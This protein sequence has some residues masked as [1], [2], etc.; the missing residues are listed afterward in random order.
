MNDNHIIVCGQQVAIGPMLAHMMLTSQDLQDCLLGLVAQ[1]TAIPEKTFPIIQFGDIVNGTIT[2]DLENFGGFPVLTVR[3]SDDDMTMTFQHVGGDSIEELE[4]TVDTESDAI[5]MLDTS[6]GDP[7][8]E[9]RPRLLPFADSL[10]WMEFIQMRN[11]E[12]APSDDGKWLVTA[13]V[14]EDHLDAGLQREAEAARR[15]A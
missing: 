15:A 4:I 3:Y 11:I 1:E 13:D 9:S 10:G 5:A 7:R 6:V 8:L 14:W 12:A 2:L